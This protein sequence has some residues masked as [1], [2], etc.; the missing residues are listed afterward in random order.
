[1]RPVIKYAFSAIFAF[2]VS[3][4][5]G[6]E[7]LKSQVREGEANGK[8]IEEAIL[9]QREWNTANAKSLKTK[10]KIVSIL[11]GFKRTMHHDPVLMADL[12]IRKSAQH[13]LD[14]FLVLGMIKTESDFNSMAVSNKGAMGLMQIQ[15]TT[16]LHLAPYGNFGSEKSER[17]RLD[18]E[19][20]ISLGTMYISKLLHRFGK[21]ELALEAYNRGPEGL[22]RDIAEG[23]YNGSYYAGKVIHHYRQYKFGTYPS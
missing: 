12:I 13:K 17:L 9:A 7:Y 2:G 4:V 23:D 21:L 15:P 14:P 20:N 3:Y 19:L 8:Q 22:H 11:S 6:T 10:A 16:A 1:M 18:N 5:I